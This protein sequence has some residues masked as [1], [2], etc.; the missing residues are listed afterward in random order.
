MI[1]FI[2][3]RNCLYLLDCSTEYKLRC[4]AGPR[5]ALGGPRAALVASGDKVKHTVTD[6]HALIVE[7]VI[8]AMSVGSCVFSEQPRMF[9]IVAFSAVRKDK[10]STP[11]AYTREFETTTRSK[12]SQGERQKTYNAPADL[13]STPDT[14]ITEFSS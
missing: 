4:V 11:C 6:L 13:C 12:R 7:V 10:D 2:D 1:S 9:G 14:A 5:A 3:T 8:P